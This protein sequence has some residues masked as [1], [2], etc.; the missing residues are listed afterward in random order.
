MAAA[1]AATAAAAAFRAATFRATAAFG[2]SR[3]TGGA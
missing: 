2:S 3:P 1:A